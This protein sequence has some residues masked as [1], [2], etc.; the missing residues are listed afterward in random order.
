MDS[1]VHFIGW[2]SCTGEKNGLTH[3]V[4]LALYSKLCGKKHRH[5]WDSNQQPLQAVSYYNQIA[6][7][8]CDCADS[9]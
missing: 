2:K 8:D 1:L 5:G 3:S 6:Q 9:Q 4:W 7:I